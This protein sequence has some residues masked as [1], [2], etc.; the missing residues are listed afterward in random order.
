MNIAAQIANNIRGVYFGGNWTVSNMKEHLDSV[1]FTQATTQV[2]GFNTI[3]TLLF[4]SNYYIEAAMQVL[5]GLPLTSSDKYSF[6][7]PPLHSEADWQNMLEMSWEQAEQ[8]AKLV[9]QLPD[10]QLFE[11]FSDKKY[12]SYFRNLQGIIEHTHYHLGQIVLIKKIILQESE[13]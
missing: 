1:N 12:G 6:T 3:A 8:L 9:E 10:S 13:K 5:N 4:H 11:D 7:H 2:F